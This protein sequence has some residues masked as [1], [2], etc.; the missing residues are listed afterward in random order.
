M[1]R[2]KVVSNPYKREIAYFTYKQATDSWDNIVND[3]VNSRLREIDKDKFFLPFM[4]K[5]ILDTIIEEYYVGNEKVELIFEGTSDEYD[6]FRQLCLDEYYSSK[7]ELVRSDKYLENARDL[8][9]YTKNIF[10]VVKPAVSKVIDNNEV[11]ND[12]LY[13][14]DDALKDIIPVCI[15]GNYSSGK[16]TFINALIGHEILPTGG[17]P[18]TA[19]IYEIHNSKQDDIARIS[20]AH[21]G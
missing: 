21:N 14:V 6:E 18:I 13:K 16:S 9:S 17:E 1:T 5:S 12:G 15:F 7:I 20:F 4:A 11:I 10:K 3:S 8:L 2:I 19:K